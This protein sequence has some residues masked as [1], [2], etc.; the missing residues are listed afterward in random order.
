M[1]KNTLVKKLTIVF[2]ILFQ[3]ALLPMT[4]KQK[5]VGGA[6]FV[7]FLSNF[8]IYKSGARTVKNKIDSYDTSIDRYKSI[9]KDLK[10]FKRQL[11]SD[12]DDTVNEDDFVG[13]M[14]MFFINHKDN[15]KLNLE[16]CTEKANKIQICYTYDPENNVEYEY[17]IVDKKKGLFKQ[18]VNLS[19]KISRCANGRIEILESEKKYLQDNKTEHSW[20]GIEG[21]NI[22]LLALSNFILIGGTFS[23]LCAEEN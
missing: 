13:N 3:I 17:K 23:L 16:P 2:M 20:L 12:D 4:P 1:K 11:N 5:L 19:N 18:Y 21:E 7:T 22:G 8:L 10:K 9:A 15:V 6:V 14:E